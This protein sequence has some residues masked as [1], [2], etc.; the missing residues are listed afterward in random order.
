MNYMYL[1]KKIAESVNVDNE[2]VSTIGEAVS[3]NESIF[4]KEQYEE[5]MNK[6][7]NGELKDLY[8]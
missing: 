5:Q 4:N 1:M 7:L 3:K 8:C 6:F 2:K